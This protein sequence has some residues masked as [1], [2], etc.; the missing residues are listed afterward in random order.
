ML[1]SGGGNPW[2]PPARGC[3]ARAGT[4]VKV[5]V[6]GAGAIGGIVAARLALAG[7]EVTVFARGLNHAAIERDGLA[8]TQIDGRREVARVHA[9]ERF[10]DERGF[11]LVIVA[12]KSHQL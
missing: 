8:I 2:S 12:V 11:D 9:S 5:A 10:E 6:V 1:L 7:E 3:R 4:R